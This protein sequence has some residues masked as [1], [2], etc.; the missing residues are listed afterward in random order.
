MPE[1]TAVIWDM[2]GVLA[3]TA[4]YHFLAWRETFAKRGIDFTKE[5]FERGFG[6]RN[7]AIIRNIMGEKTADTEIETIAKEKEATFR[8]LIG[9]DIKPLPGVLELLSQLNDQ[10]IRMAIASS[11]VI[12]NIHLITGSLG[13]E[14]YFEAIITGHDVTEG[15]PSPQ[16][17]LVAAQRLGADPKNCVVFED[18]VAGVKAAKSAGMHCV[19]IT[20]SNPREKLAEADLVVDSLAEVSV[21]DLEKLLKSNG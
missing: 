18:A 21:N 19:A 14:N 5:D 17:F 11:T 12:E 9:Q 13:I 20:S 3:D 8:R 6:I 4:P 1:L 7:D 15:K 2:D 16:V 10:G